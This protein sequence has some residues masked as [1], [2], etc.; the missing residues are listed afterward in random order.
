MSGA[1]P[2]EADNNQAMDVGK[3]GNQMASLTRREL[4]KELD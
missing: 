1:Q 2:A 3:R 4:V